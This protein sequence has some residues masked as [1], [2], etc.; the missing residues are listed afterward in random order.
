LAG[1]GSGFGEVAVKGEAPAEEDERERMASSSTG[2]FLRRVPVLSDLD[3]DLL[4][5]LAEQVDEVSVRAGE[6]LVR[7]GDVADSLYLIRSGR[8][9]VVVEGPPETVIRVLRRGEVLGEL[10]LLTEQVRSASVRAWTPAPEDQLG[11]SRVPPATVPPEPGGQ[12]GHSSKWVQRPSL[13]SRT[14]QMSRYS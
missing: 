13:L 6:W 1:Y 8:L 3:D 9:E 4:D 10:A 2:A 7:E 12:N 5:R 11:L 14:I